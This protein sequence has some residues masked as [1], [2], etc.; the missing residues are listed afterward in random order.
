MVDIIGRKFLCNGE[1]LTVVSA[2]ASGKHMRFKLSDGSTRVD[3]DKADI[4][5]AGGGGVLPQ[6]KI[7]T[8]QP[9]RVEK[10]SIIP[11]GTIEDVRDSIN[12]G[13]DLMD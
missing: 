4:E 13:E 8:T 9:L 6:K 12:N 11:S 7:V 5:W 2:V 1:W 3:L 10:K